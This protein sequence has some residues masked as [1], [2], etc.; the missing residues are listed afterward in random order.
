MFIPRSRCANFKDP[1]EAVVCFELCKNDK[2]LKSI[3]GKNIDTLTAA[4][5]LGNFVSNVACTRQYNYL[6]MLIN[7]IHY[8]AKLTREY[9]RMYELTHRFLFC[10]FRSCRMGQKIFFARQL[11]KMVHIWRTTL[12]TRRFSVS[13]R[14]CDRIIA[15][16]DEVS[17][18]ISIL[19]HQE[20]QTVSL[21]RW[22]R[23]AGELYF[24]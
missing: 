18:N 21:S 14:F 9:L 5:T 11:R 2:E 22:L 1:R 8:S 20:S 19:T 7:Y 6:N 24:S 17:A 3:G 16:F 12:L 15:C 10:K 4:V 13:C 23:R